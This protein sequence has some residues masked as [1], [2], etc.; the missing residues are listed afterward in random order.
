MKDS[1]LGNIGIIG[2]GSWGTA[3]AKIL[4]DN[5]NQIHWWVRNSEA[6]EQLKNRG[7]NPHYLTSVR[8]PQNSILPT[9]NL[10]DVL[11][12]CKTVIM[13]VPSAYTQDVFKSVD[14]SLWKDKQIISAIK[15]I[16]PDCNLL[17]NDYLATHD[18]FNLQN[19]VAITGPCHAEEVAQ[20]RLSYL[21]FSGLNDTLTSAVAK[22][23]QNTYLYTTYN[24]DI[25]GAQFAAVL[26]NIYAIGAGIAHGLDYGD[27]FLSV[28]ITNCYREMYRFLEMHFDK[29]HP[30]NERPDFHTSAYLGDLLVTCYSLHSRNRMFGTMLGKG[31]SVQNAQLEMNM[32][33]EGYYASRGMETI[34]ESLGIQHPIAS[35]IYS[36]LWDGVQ[37]REMFEKLQKTLS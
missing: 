10:A 4:T 26:K 30:S 22:A 29:V 27:N 20:E 2:N 12:N 7:N 11:Q 5:N 17:F 18:W 14:T 33:A 34:S 13:G 24:H 1:V 15:G 25:W 21:T 36:V 32:V 9:N 23:F 35:S 28:Y 37:P 6:L 16:L 19:Y 3:L 8:F 31:Y